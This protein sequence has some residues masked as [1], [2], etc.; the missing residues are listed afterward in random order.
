MSAARYLAGA[1]RRRVRRAFERHLLGCVDCWGEVHLGARGRG[2][3]ESGREDAPQGLRE[4]IRGAVLLA[5]VGE[6]GP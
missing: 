6:A 1:M 2:F 4:R 3:A 5:A